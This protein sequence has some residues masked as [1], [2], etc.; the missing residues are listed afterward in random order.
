M[1]NYGAHSYRALFRFYRKHFSYAVVVTARA[2]VVTASSLLWAWNW[3]GSK[4]SK[5]LVYRQNEMDLKQV[6]R[7][8]F[9]SEEPI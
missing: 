9:E 1:R 2:I 3:T 6:I 8:C 5:R 4:L 7:V